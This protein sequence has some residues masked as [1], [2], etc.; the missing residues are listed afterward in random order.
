MR[1]QVSHSAINEHSAAPRVI[2]VGSHGKSPFLISALTTAGLPAQ[3]IY[4]LAVNNLDAIDSGTLIPAPN[5]YWPELGNTSQLV[6]WDGLA[7]TQALT[8]SLA[9]IGHDPYELLVLDRF[10]RNRRAAD[11]LSWLNRIHSALRSWIEQVSPSLIVAE[12]GTALEAVVIGI[13]REFGILHVNPSSARM[14]SNRFAL[15]TGPR[16]EELLPLSSRVPDAAPAASWLQSWLE[17]QQRPN[18]A[19]A[20]DNRQPLTTVRLTRSVARVYRRAAGGRHRQMQDFRP[21]DY[22]R[23]PWLNSVR[24]WR[25]GRAVP[26]Y[27]WASADKLTPY[28]FYPLHVQPEASVDVFGPWRDQLETA[29]RL[30]AEIECLGLKLV[31]KDHS[32]FVW[33]RDRSFFDALLGMR[34]VS[35]VS[36]YSSTAALCHNAVATFTVSGT[37]AFEC[38]LQSLRA[39]TVANMPWSTLPTVTQVESIDNVCNELAAGDEPISRASRSEV[40]HWFNDYWAMTRPGVI[41]DVYSNPGIMSHDNLERVGAVLLSAAQEHAL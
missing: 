33:R 32:N 35:L 11:A 6:P 18:Y 25:Q 29:R 20:N 41:S 12:T 40:Y 4:L 3:Q 15:W 38:G 19:I 23:E 1:G 7:A 2:I 28:L 8:A 34:N 30:A 9:Q 21:V 10:L 26:L 16:S 31:V 36:P 22:L 37:V 13:A 24:S 5:S 14:P 27:P 39:F 17:Q